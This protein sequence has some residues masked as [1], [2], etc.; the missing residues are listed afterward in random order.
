M[1]V[2]V[3]TNQPLG[4]MTWRLAGLKRFRELRGVPQCLLASAA[5]A[6]LLLAGC[7]KGKVSSTDSAA[8]SPTTASPTTAVDAAGTGAQQAYRDCLE[9]NGIVIPAGGGRGQGGR[10]QGNQTDP[11]AAS[12][13]TSAP[14]AD[15][16]RVTIDQA[17]RDKAQ[18]ACG[19]LQPQQGQGGPGGGVPGGQ[20]RVGVPAM[21]H[22]THTFPA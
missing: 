19:S 12:S 14:A 18:A 20:V 8:A 15:T 13:S 22:T 7:G 10:G 4:C 16:T 11:S 17:T 21:L 2:S 1:C 3:L 6:V 5:V 9:K